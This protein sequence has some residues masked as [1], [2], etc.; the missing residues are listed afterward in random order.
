MQTP[1]QIT[2]RHAE[3]SEYLNGLIE[4]KARELEHFNDRV[5]ACRVLV[6]GPGGHHRKGKGATFHLRIE[7]LVPG[8]VLVVAR[9]VTQTESGRDAFQ[10]VNEAFHAV[11]RQ[12]E[13]WVRLR[14]EYRGVRASPPA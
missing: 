10:G 3:A 2:Y 6:D 8:E 9:D 1:L 4:A 13:D 14:R 12:L 7:L 5:T 11:R